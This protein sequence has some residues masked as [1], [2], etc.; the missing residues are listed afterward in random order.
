MQC[1]GDG[2]CCITIFSFVVRNLR[3][4]RGVLCRDR[5]A[6]PLGPQHNYNIYNLDERKWT[7][8]KVVIL[9]SVVK[10]TKR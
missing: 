6:E 4:F 3:N 1:L 7:M 8:D 10:L 5:E 9:I 2:A